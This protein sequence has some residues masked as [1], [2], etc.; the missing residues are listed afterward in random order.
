MIIIKVTIKVILSISSL[1]DNLS[2]PSPQTEIHNIYIADSLYETLLINISYMITHMS[3]ACHVKGLIHMWVKHVCST[4]SLVYTLYTL[5]LCSIF[6]CFA[7]LHSTQLLS[8]SR[9][10]M[11]VS[12][13]GYCSAIMYMLVKSIYLIHKSNP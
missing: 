7:T 4:C 2:L 3:E 9:L 10:N 1:S 8:L 5:K 12:I 11:I 6:T 13:V